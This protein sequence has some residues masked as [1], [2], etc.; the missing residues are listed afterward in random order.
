MI[1]VHN[2]TGTTEQI[3]EE[4]KKSPD[5]FLHFDK[6]C[7]PGKIVLLSDLWSKAN[8]IATLNKCTLEIFKNIKNERLID[9][10][11][12]QEDSKSFSFRSTRQLQSQFLGAK[13]HWLCNDIKINGLGYPVQGFMKPGGG[14]AS[15]PGTYRYFASFV[16][17]IDGLA[18][19]WDTENIFPKP[20]LSIEKWIEF[21]ITGKIRNHVTIEIKNNDS[22]E[23][24][25]HQHWK[26]LEIHFQQN[27]HDHCIF[28]N[29]QEL[30]KMY[31]YKLPTIYYSDTDVYNH[32]VK[33]LSRPEFF[34]FKK[35]ENK[36]MIP[37]NENFEGVSMYLN[38][39]YDDD[40]TFLFLYLDI[41]DDVAYSEDKQTI[42]FNNSS[43]NCKKLIPEIVQES[44]DEYLENFFWC[45][46]KSTMPKLLERNL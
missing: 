30:G 41:N 4:C 18:F 17:Q 39:L 29:D 11:I 9:Q 44:A 37:S 2:V 33:T 15:H 12:Y 38:K 42:I 20:P 32:A 35:I 7:P 1:H 25:Q 16:Q 34:K 3:I 14:Y 21:C 24:N 43:F 5:L 31:N 13:L 8:P 26:Y 27:H 45:S 28:L 23:E 10:V 6:Y 36:F 22:L 46:K 40:F 19:V